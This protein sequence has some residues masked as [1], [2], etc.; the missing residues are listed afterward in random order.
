MVPGIVCIDIDNKEEENNVITCIH[1]RYSN[2]RVVIVTNLTSEHDVPELIKIGDDFLELR[3]VGSIYATFM[4]MD[5]TKQKYTVDMETILRNGGINTEIK[6]TAFVAT[7]NQL[8]TRK[9]IH[10]LLHM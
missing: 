7:M 9:I 8:L 2:E 6:N 1:N 5:S 10:K 3:Y 4:E